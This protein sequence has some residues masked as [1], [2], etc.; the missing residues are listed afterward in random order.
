MKVIAWITARAVIDRILAHGAKA[1]LGS[2][3]EARGTPA[4]G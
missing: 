3:F 4:L 2:P 1:G